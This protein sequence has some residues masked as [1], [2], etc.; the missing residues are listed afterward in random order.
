MGASLVGNAVLVL[1]DEVAPVGDEE[2]CKTACAEV[3]P[4]DG[5]KDG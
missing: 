4:A 1:N 2:G 5:C 3:S